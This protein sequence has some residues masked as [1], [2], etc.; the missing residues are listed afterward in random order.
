MTAEIFEKFNNPYINELDDVVLSITNK[1]KFKKLETNFYIHS[2]ILD[3]EA[4]ELH[5]LVMKIENVGGIPICVKTDCVLFYCEEL[6]PLDISNEFWESGT[7]KYKYEEMPLMLKNEIIIYNQNKL[8]IEPSAY[9]NLD[10]DI[11]IAEIIKPDV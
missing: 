4:V 6:K 10:E 7:L 2:Q 3:I 9:T 8:I 5:K 1:K 11:T